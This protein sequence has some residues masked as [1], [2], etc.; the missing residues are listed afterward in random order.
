M[1]DITSLFGLSFAAVGIDAWITVAFVLAILAA[2]GGYFFFVRPE[3]TYPNKFVNWFRDFL[4]FKEMFIE[5][6]LK[7]TYIFVTVYMVL[8]SFSLIRYSFMTFITYFLIG[9][10]G[11]RVVYEASMVLLGI[12]SNTKEINKKMKK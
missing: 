3:K 12:W 11:T 8:S 10:V 1:S 7:I 4:N 9:V 6:I 5:P 2:V